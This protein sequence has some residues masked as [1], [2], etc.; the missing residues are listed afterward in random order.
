MLARDSIVKLERRLVVDMASFSD[1]MANMLE[2]LKLFDSSPFHPGAVLR[3][4]LDEKGWTQDELAAVMGKSRQAINELIVG[5]TGITPEMAIGLAAAF[6]NS[7]TDWMK[8]DAAY[9]LSLAAADV[10]EVQR[11]ARLYEIAPVR[12]MQKRGWIKSTKD[13][14]ELELEL[15]R[16]FE[17]DELDADIA[18]PVNTF[19]PKRLGDLNPAERAWCFR[20][21]QLAAYVPVEQRFDVSTIRMLERDLRGLTAYPQHVAKVPRL[22]AKYGIRLVIVEP[23]P[24]GKIDGVAFW[25]AKDSPVIAVTVR[26]DQIDRFWFVLMHEL[27]HIRNKDE[28][29]IDVDLFR[30]GATLL[31]QEKHEQRANEEAAAALI[32][33]QE[34]TSFIRRVGPLYSRARIIQFAH[35]MKIHPGV[36][37]GQLQHHGAV[38]FSS[39]QQLL[40]K[41]RN[42]V[43][44]TTL[45][46]GWGKTISSEVG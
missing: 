37:V 27:A 21:R 4:M 11:K 35:R 33:P 9:R 17:T 24:S 39:H 20:A 32:A 2:E 10:A 5:K 18:F 31:L 6:G 16:F 3:R 41:I 40:A 25:I 28:P 36:I 29:S 15:K 1:N 34:L 44:E 13:T 23:L 12:D 46:D 45:T 30:E 14:A 43:T 19:R 26:Y 7:A 38:K 8:I 42:L 22:L